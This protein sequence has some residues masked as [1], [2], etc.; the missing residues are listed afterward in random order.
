MNARGRPWR[1]L[2]LWF[3]FVTSPG[4]E[5]VEGAEGGFCDGLRSIGQVH[6]DPAHPW[7]QR[8]TFHARL[9]A[10]WSRSTGNFDGREFEAN[11]AGL[12]RLW[13]GF[14]FRALD[15]LTGVVSVM[16]NTGSFR[17]GE[18]GYRSFDFLNLNYKVG[19]LGG[20]EDVKVGYGRYLIGFGGEWHYSANEMI[21]I[22]RSNLAEYFGV[23]RVTGFRFLAKR[24]RI[25]WEGA[26]TTTDRND[27][28]GEWKGGKAYYLGAEIPVGG[29]RVWSDF[30][31]VDAPRNL[32]EIYGYDWAA[33][34]A[35]DGPVGDWHLM[36]NAVISEV[37]DD[38]TYGVVLM[39][40]HFLIEDR[41]ELVVRYQY[42]A[43]EGE[44]V[45]IIARNLRN[46]VAYDLRALVPRGSEDHTMYAGLNYY[47]CGHHAKVMTGV[48]YE[49]LKGRDVDL[50]GVTFWTAFRAYF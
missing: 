38:I 5:P 9:H 4:L 10:Q 31:Y 20:F 37:D 14:S 41:L 25:Q 7:L 50:E 21:F 44:Q 45:G 43:S 34:L 48:E 27:I 26:V 39:P 18:V 28:L 15:R 29:G 35:W 8:L 17:N 33:S 1:A 16:W 42:Y 2:L 24:H 32:D 19:N 22:E 47:F 36:A 49:S 46:S 3:V 6:I 11:G 12:R 23:D 13:A 30:Y 40:S